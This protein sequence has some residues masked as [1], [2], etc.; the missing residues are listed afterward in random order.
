MTFNQHENYPQTGDDYMCGI[1]GKFSLDGRQPVDPE[2]IKRMTDVIAHRGPDGE[3]QH[4]TGPIGLG[5][6]R[7]S[8]IDLNTGSQPMCNED[9]TVWIVFNGEIYNYLLLRAELKAQGHTF[10][11]ASDTEVIV[12][13]YEELGE[14]CVSR[15]QG[16]FS[17]AIWDEHK[18]KLLLARDRVGIKP[19]YYTNTGTELL[20]ASEIK[21]LFVDTSVARNISTRGVDRFLTYYYLPGNETLFENIYKLDPGHYLTVSNGQIKKCQYW[22]LHFGISPRWERFDEAVEALQELLQRS[23]KDHMISDVPVGVL[24]S[25]GVDS[26][27]V[28]RYAVE[29]SDQPIHTF[30]VGFEGEAFPDE[31]PFARLAAQHFGTIHQE[32]TISAAD[33]CNFLPKYIWHMEEPVCE[34]PAFALYLVSR[35]ARESSVKVLLSGEGGD[36]AFGGYSKYRNLLAL[37]GLKSAFGSARG[38]LSFGIEALANLGWKRIAKYSNLINLP[39]SQYYFSF[40]ATPDTPFNRQKHTL[41]NKD[42]I[43]FLGSRASDEPTRLLFEQADDLPLLHQML[44]V[45]TKSWLPDDLLVK[46]DKM[47]MATSVELRVPLLDSRVLEFAASLPPHFKVRGLTT[48]RILKAALKDSVPSAIL[49]RKKTGFPVPYDRWLKNEMK[50]FVFETLLNPNS[51]LR[52]YF[53]KESL[54]KMIEMNQRGEGYSQ[55]I[56]SLLV[57]ELLHQQFV[58]GRGVP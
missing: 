31:R 29:Q 54:I 22:D 13:L 49:N 35:L 58:E 42:F 51:N 45:D 47:T 14:Q 30:T 5:H 57:L 55:E 24:L 36:E 26:T 27:G 15:L 46:A 39:L 18:Q 2:L 50:D 48:K 38:S 6:R 32:I 23:V 37:E 3:G 53:C 25:G 40:T 28:L 44:Y 1:V 33:F 56:F 16:M 19:L 20:F 41:Y 10:K 52:N 21:A 34:P 11:S 43:K 4:V 7:L 8:I 17:F 12:H 9:G